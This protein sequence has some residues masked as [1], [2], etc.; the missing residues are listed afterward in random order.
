MGTACHG[1]PGIQIPFKKELDFASFPSLSGLSCVLRLGDAPP[2]GVPFGLR[3][4]KQIDG[5][6]SCSLT[7]HPF[8]QPINSWLIT[9]PFSKTCELYQIRL[10]PSFF[11][12]F[13][14]QLL[15]DLVDFR[16]KIHNLQPFHALSSR[17]SQ[18]TEFAL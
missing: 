8:G 10:A 1:V 11:G 16:C 17:L 6:Q 9:G 12:T 2:A 13:A 15:A 18:A 14:Q 4:L 7:Q 5:A 3:L